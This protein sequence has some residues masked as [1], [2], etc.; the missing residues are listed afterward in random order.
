[1]TKPNLPRR[2]SAAK[3]GAREQRPEETP[4][5]AH[6]DIGAHG[7]L[8]T[9][10]WVQSA[11]CPHPDFLSC[12]VTY[13]AAPSAFQN[14]R[15]VRL[16]WEN[17]MILYCFLCFLPDCT[18]QARL[19]RCTYSPELYDS[20]SRAGAVANIS[21]LCCHQRKSHAC[22]GCCGFCLLDCIPGPCRRH[23][24]QGRHDSVRQATQGRYGRWLF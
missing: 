23:Q 22:S 11:P 9:L 10:H 14:T 16:A 20:S 19:R 3:L 4:N 21:A 5:G 17:V 13:G 2:L 8:S 1:M 18:K 7:D 24:L 15:S 12:Q 6:M